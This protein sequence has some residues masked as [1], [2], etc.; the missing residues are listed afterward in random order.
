MFLLALDLN[1]E[2]FAGSDKTLSFYEKTVDQEASLKMWKTGD[3]GLPLLEDASWMIWGIFIHNVQV[4]AD[5]ENPKHSYISTSEVHHAQG[6]QIQG[7]DIHVL[8]QNLMHLLYIV[9]KKLVEAFGWS[10]FQT[11]ECREVKWQLAESLVVASQIH[12]NIQLI[13]AYIASCSVALTS[14]ISHLSY[15]YI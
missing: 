5:P 9:F 12:A 4:V 1:L 15:I 11:S 8:Y 7:R 13:T 6:L 10:L 2:I 14:S 3:A